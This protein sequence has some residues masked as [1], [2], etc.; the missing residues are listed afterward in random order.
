MKLKK[1]TRKISSHNIWNYYVPKKD[2]KMECSICHK[3]YK[4]SIVNLKKYFRK[5]HSEDWKKIN[6]KKIDSQSKKINNLK[7]GLRVIFNDS[8]DNLDKINFKRVKIF[9]D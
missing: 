2:N 4:N 9:Y 5:F 6:K 3:E 7:R 8:F 1:I